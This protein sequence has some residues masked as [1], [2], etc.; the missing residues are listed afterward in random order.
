MKGGAIPKRSRDQWMDS[1]SSDSLAEQLATLVWLS[2]THL[3]SSEKR[4]ENVD[5][6]SVEDSTLF[7]SV[8][9]SDTTRKT[10]NELQNS[11]VK[12]VQEYAKLVID[13]LENDG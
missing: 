9:N 12:W 2:G 13:S 3:K 11:E 6:E 1:L 10:L 5:Q 4:Y 7:E 8:R